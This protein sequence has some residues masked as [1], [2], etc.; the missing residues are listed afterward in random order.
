[1]RCLLLSLVLSCV[2]NSMEAQKRTID[3]VEKNGSV[4]H[5]NWD[6]ISHIEFYPDDSFLLKSVDGTSTSYS[7]G[8]KGIIFNC[9]P[10][11]EFVSPIGEWEF[12]SINGMTEWDR[13]TS[14]LL[15]GDRIQICSNGRIYDKWDEFAVWKKGG[16]YALSD[17][18]P[19]LVYF[20]I[21]IW[22]LTDQIFNFDIKLFGLTANIVL[23]RVSNEDRTENPFIF[24]DDDSHNPIKEDESEFV[25]CLNWDCSSEGVKEYMKQYQWT[26]ESEGKGSIKYVNIDETKEVYYYFSQDSLGMVIGYLKYSE[27]KLQDIINTIQE[28]YGA[29]LDETVS[30]ERYGAYYY[31]NGEAILNG[32]KCNIEVRTDK[33]SNISISYYVI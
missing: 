12:V 8:I 11:N 31:F 20:T 4:Q 24:D 23:K 22:E 1:M 29:V 17:S 3:I 5:I 7:E 30:F 14:D 26:K 18:E 27:K 10:E 6:N 9:E 15:P 16:P 25:P 21:K 32:E 33:K 19:H 2:V 28:K 13:T